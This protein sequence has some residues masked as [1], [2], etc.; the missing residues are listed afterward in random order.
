MIL[1]LK[2]KVRDP[3]SFVSLMSASSIQLASEGNTNFILCDF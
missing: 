2:L 3:C 1:L